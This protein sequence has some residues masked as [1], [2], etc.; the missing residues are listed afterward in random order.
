[1]RNKRKLET[2]LQTFFLNFYQG[3]L[4]ASLFCELI[5]HGL[6][7]IP[8]L[9]ILNF[10]IILPMSRPHS[11]CPSFKILP[12]NSS[13]PK[14][15]CSLVLC[16]NRYTWHKP[17][18]GGIRWRCCWHFKG[19]LQYVCTNQEMTSI[20]NQPQF[21][22]HAHPNTWTAAEAV[23]SLLT[24]RLLSCEFERP[25]KRASFNAFSRMNARDSI[26]HIPK[27]H[28]IEYHY[29]KHKNKERC[30]LPNTIE[31]T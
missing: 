4:L 15:R 29:Y 7:V 12:P 30:P 19:C 27:F 26:E 8:K 14:K 18:A 16:G 31:G 21:R 6:D 13:S 1:M 11:E 17:I 22:N 9:T 10:T 28:D 24:Q 23:K 20:I 3:F 5:H 2:P 25:T